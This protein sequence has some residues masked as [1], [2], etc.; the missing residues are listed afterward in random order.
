THWSP[1]GK[2]LSYLG[3]GGAQAEIWVTDASTGE[4]HV[5][6][7]AAHLRDV[8]L[9]PASRG[10]QTGLGRLTPSQYRWTPD[11][12]ALLFIGA[13]QLAWYDLKSQTSRHLLPESASTDANAA[14]DDAKISPDGHWVSFIRNH[15]IWI[16]GV[17]VVTLAPAAVAG[18]PVIQNLTRNGSE[19][20][21][22]GELDW[23]YPEELDLQTSYWWS[24]DST[25][26]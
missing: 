16:V 4:K 13:Q 19:T 17:T 21:R 26:V 6:V 3:G 11:S 25:R 20:L 5:L 2:W 1:D 7:D 22:N 23:V 9:P 24:P 10:Q 12:Q 18:Q 15:D 14:I 8:L